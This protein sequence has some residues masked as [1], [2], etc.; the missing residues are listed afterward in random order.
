MFLQNVLVSPSMG[1]EV[2]M[3]FWIGVEVLVHT[4]V[5]DI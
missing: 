4:G 5:Q 1:T 3:V 2:K